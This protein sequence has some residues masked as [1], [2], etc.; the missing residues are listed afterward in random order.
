NEVEETKLKSDNILSTAQHIFSN[1]KIQLNNHS[2]SLEGSAGSVLDAELDILRQL[3][4][5]MKFTLKN[6]FEPNKKDDHERM[7]RNLEGVSKM[8]SIFNPMKWRWD[9][10]QQVEITVSN[11]EINDQCEITIEGR[12]SQNKL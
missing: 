8:L 2:L 10:E 11:N 1:I 5:E 4:V 9:A 7:K 3:V 6:T 12:D